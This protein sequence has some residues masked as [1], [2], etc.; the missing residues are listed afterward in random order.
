MYWSSWNVIQRAELDGAN[1]AS[2]VSLS[3]YG[4]YSVNS[5]A[6]DVDM[7]RIYFASSQSVMFIDLY[8]STRPVETLIDLYSYW[9]F[10]AYP[11][12]IAVDD[13]Y[14]YF[15]FP[16]GRGQGNVYRTNK[17]RK[18]DHLTFV[19]SGLT[20]PRE[21]VIHKGNATGKCKYSLCY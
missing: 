11:S 6:M 17:R 13:N 5:L 16:W 14:V 18:N 8:S 12:G 1:Q 3:K 19:L 2:V 4:V 7:N 10:Y 20:Y 21:I 15:A 9:H